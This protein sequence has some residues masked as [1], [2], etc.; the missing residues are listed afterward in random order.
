MSTKT[1]LAFLNSYVLQFY[2]MKRF[3]VLKVLK[4]N[5]MQLP[6]PE[7]TVEQ[8]LVIEKYVNQLLS[9]NCSH[10][11]PREELESEIFKLYQLTTNEAILIKE[12][13]CKSC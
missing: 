1:V 3:N 8:N 11:A 13:I 10:I 4:S 2:Y 12:E 9:N 5:L 7:I 6:F